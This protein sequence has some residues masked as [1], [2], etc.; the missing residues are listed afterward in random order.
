MKVENQAWEQG[1]KRYIMRTFVARSAR[2]KHSTLRHA[3]SS[4]IRQLAGARMTRGWRTDFVRVKNELVVACLARLTRGRAN[5]RV[6]RPRRYS[7][8]AHERRADA[9]GLVQI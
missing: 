9:R 1:Y 2:E 8:Q 6:F 4:C 3:L 7:A 5:T